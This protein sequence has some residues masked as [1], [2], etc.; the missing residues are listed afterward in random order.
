MTVDAQGGTSSFAF[1]NLKE[2]AGLGDD[3]FVFK[4]PRGVDVVTSRP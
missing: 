4:P 2:N 3:Q 1:T